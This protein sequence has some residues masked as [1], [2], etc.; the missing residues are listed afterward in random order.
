M[1][2]Y[3]V[4]ALPYPGRGHINPMMTLCKQLATRQPEI[5]ITFV[6][7]EEWLGFIGSEPKPDN[8]RFGTIPNVI[9]SELGRAK[10]FPGFM[11]AV[12]TK[13]EAPF[14]E[15]LDRIE[16]PVTAIVAD[17]YMV[18]VPGLERGHEIVDYIP[19]LSPTRLANLPTIFYGTSK[20]TLDRALKCVGEVS[21]AQY[22]LF[23]S[24]YM[25]EAQVM[26]SLQAEFSF[27]VYSMDPPFPT[28]NSIKL[29]ESVLYVSLGSFLSVSRTQMDE[30][31][32]GVRNSG[33]RFFFVARGES[34]TLFKDGCGEMGM[35]V[36]WCDQLRV[37]CHS[38]VGGFWTHCGFNSTLEGVY[39]GV[40][41]L[42]FPIFWDQVPNSIKEMAP[43]HFFVKFIG[44]TFQF[45]IVNPEKYT[46]YA[47]CC[48]VYM[49][50]YSTFPEPTEKFKVEINLPWTGRY[51]VVEDDIHLQKI[52]D[53]LTA[54]KFNKVI[55][56]ID[57]LP[58]AMEPSFQ[59]DDASSSCQRTPG[60]N[61]MLE[62][63]QISDDEMSEDNRSHC[64]KD[65]D[66]Q[67]DED[68]N[69][70]SSGWISEEADYSD[71]SEEE[72][73]DELSSNSD[74][75]VEDEV[76][77]DTESDEDQMSDAASF[78]FD[79]D[80]MANGAVDEESDSSTSGKTAKGKRRQEIGV[81]G[82]SKSAPKRKK[83]TVTGSSTNNTAVGGSSNV[84]VGPSSQQVSQTA[85]LH[86]SQP[87]SQSEQVT[88]TS[89]NRENV[90]GL[91]VDWN[92][93]F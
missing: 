86:A 17:T 87:A 42:T 69:P 72:A 31:V 62:V 66:S 12:L 93:P 32:V 76:L 80:F 3:H 11:E 52:L 34:L 4:V 38:S 55:M 77:E 85:P 39:A 18:W 61:T 79:N 19:G 15:L 57:L 46:L 43:L 7:T 92:G 30:I 58:L 78:E 21:K 50:Q 26:E 24:V 28:F 45:R 9:P 13:T 16:Y 65:T 83:I 33:V 35:I 56:E 2:I 40:P 71:S 53:I 41:M 8:I 47:L 70:I 64:L 37:L 1:G 29:P 63:V 91:D 44:L 27:S 74:I 10:D 59:P 75:G 60:Q 22:L 36:P 88:R 5:L 90:P 82:S 89:I 25:L 67:E 68:Y 6:V 23:T 20:Q 49:L 84:V 48:N 54:R 51:V 73:E 14:E 81:A